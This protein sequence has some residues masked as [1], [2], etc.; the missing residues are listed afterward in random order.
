MLL[1]RLCVSSL[2][3]SAEL[4]FTRTMAAALSA[5]VCAELLLDDTCFTSHTLKQVKV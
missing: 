5:A 3:V 1:H 4:T 2:G